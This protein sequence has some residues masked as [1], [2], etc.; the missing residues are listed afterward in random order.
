MES[1]KMTKMIINFENTKNLT[2]REAIKKDE[3]YK[4]Y[5]DSFDKFNESE[6]KKSQI[7]SDIWTF[8]NLES[9]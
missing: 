4:T 5:C 6:N 3:E 7:K 9:V 1:D 8:L 2:I